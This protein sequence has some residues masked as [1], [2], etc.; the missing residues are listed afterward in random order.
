MSTPNRWAVNQSGLVNIYDI[1]T[2]K[3]IVSLETLK[4]TSVET[5]GETKYAIGGPGNAKIVGFSTNKSAALKLQDAIFD[6]K[7]ISMLTGNNV[8]KGARV[9]DRKEVGTTTGSSL[10][11]QKTP[12]G[13]IVSVYQLNPDGTN[14]KEFTL[15][16]T[17]PGASEYSISG[18]IL[19][20]NVAVT[21]GTKFRIYYKVTTATDAQSI[22][23]SSDKFAGTYRVT[24][25][26]IVVDE[27]T[28]QAC[29]GQI[30]IPNAKFE[31]SFNISLASGSDPA[32]LDLN[33][34]I[35]K[36]ATGTTMWEMVVFDDTAIV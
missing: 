14:D 24:V 23:V 16:T 13:A 19:T 36:D 29:N 25:D 30:I 21:D 18:K 4:T 15:A 33:M 5:T 12:T 28:K 17:T 26:V 6:N 31:D 32:V 27:F 11:L 2:G 9:I 22:K 10:T 3:A 1:K 8:S 35:L 20:F 34:E 7:A